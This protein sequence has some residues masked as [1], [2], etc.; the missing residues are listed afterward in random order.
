MY[1]PK[2]SKGINKSMQHLCQHGCGQPAIHTTKGSLKGGPVHQC[3]K[4]HNSCPAI[5]EK[6]IAASVEKYGTA[7]PWQTKEIIEK[8]K[9]SNLEKYGSVCSLNNEAVSAKRKAT[10]LERYGVEQPTLNKEI[11]KKVS[12]GVLQSYINDPGL[13]AKQSANKKTMY[14]DGLESII[15]KNREIQIANG[16]WVDPALKT[17]WQQYKFTVKKL[18]SKT[19]K[20]FKHLINP[21]DLPLGVC[22]YQL[23]HI[24]SIRAGFENKVPA[25]WLA[26]TANLRMLWHA[27]NK[28]KHIRCD[29]TLRELELKIKGT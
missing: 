20:E 16:R 6:K 27:E 11:S 21:S 22:E 9:E 18:T 25:E 19:Y 10:M 23:D 1:L 7:Y 2:L 29:Q 4:S 14:G 13:K 8:R 5:K 12:A 28:S 26:H 3:A 15:Q 24:Y 17:E